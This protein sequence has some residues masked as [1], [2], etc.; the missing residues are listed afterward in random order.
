MLRRLVAAKVVI[1]WFLGAFALYSSVLPASTGSVLA[2]VVL[3]EAKDPQVPDRAICQED[4]D[5]SSAHLTVG[6]RG[7][8]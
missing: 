4:E 5:P 1:V 6:S 7:S 8:G 2:C 3:S